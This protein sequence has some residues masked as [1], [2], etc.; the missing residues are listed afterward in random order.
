VTEGSDGA[1]GSP[2]GNFPA[3][4]RAV[5]P[6]RFR[7][8]LR[9][10]SDPPPRAYK[11]VIICGLVCISHSKYYTPWNSNAARKLPSPA[12]HEVLSR[13]S[14]LFYPLR[15]IASRLGPPLAGV[16]ADPICEAVPRPVAVIAVPAILPGAREI[17]STTASGGRGSRRAVTRPATAIFPQRSPCLAS[18]RSTTTNLGSSRALV[19]ASRHFTE[20]FNPPPG[21]PTRSIRPA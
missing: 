21:P 5:V 20:F 13:S 14:H 16:P 1:P 9:S 12:H 11:L 18:F 7:A 3:T 4:S 10:F 17:G 6:P 15:G 2:C 8:V 19:T